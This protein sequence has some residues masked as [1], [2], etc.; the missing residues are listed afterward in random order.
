[1]HQHLNY[2][3]PEEE[4]KKKRHKKIFEDILVENFPNVENEII[5][6]VQEVQRVP[7]RINPGRN[8][9][10]HMLIKL[11]KIK[12]KKE[13]KKQQR[14]ATSNIQRKPNVFNS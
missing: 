13:Y 4:E 12:H 10:R 1:M 5:N 14:K 7:Y 11:A 2:W 9:P 8:M 6:Q 3:V